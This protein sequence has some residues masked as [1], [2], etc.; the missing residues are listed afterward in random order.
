MDE[1]ELREEAIR[2]YENGESPKSIC[3]T[4]NR[5][6]SWFFKWLKRYRNEEANWAE[7]R[8]RRPHNTPNRI[9]NSPVIL[10]FFFLILA[11][12][13]FPFFR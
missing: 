10:R 1:K 2:R 9:D 7:D 8:S 5:S 4:F 11:R 3:D 12:P 13:S 6:K